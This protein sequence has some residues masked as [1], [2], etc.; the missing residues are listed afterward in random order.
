MRQTGS[1]PGMRHA[2]AIKLLRLRKCNFWKI[3]EKWTHAIVKNEVFPL[4]LHL[5]A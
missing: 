5:N 1:K 2:F 4:S 3:L